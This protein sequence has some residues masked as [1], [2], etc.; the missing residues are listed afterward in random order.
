MSTLPFAS[1]LANLPAD[2]QAGQQRPAYSGRAA[3]CGQAIGRQGRLS[4]DTLTVRVGTCTFEGIDDIVLF[5]YSDCVSLE[6]V[7]AVPWSSASDPRR[8]RRAD[9]NDDGLISP[10]VRTG[11][12]QKAPI[13][14]AAPGAQARTQSW[15]P[16]PTERGG[17]S[18]AQPTAM[19]HISTPPEPSRSPSRSHSP[20][21]TA[22]S[23]ERSP[24]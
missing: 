6:K 17:N 18:D 2:D 3:C 7:G 9:E 10:G 12:A 4:S 16:R 24:G 23:T 20:F 19:R 22:A 11:F 1:G 8:T 14:G 15:F 13:A 5:S 21:G